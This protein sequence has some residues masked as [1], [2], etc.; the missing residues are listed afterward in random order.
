[1]EE[2]GRQSARKTEQPRRG[3]KHQMR[4]KGFFF[5]KEA[6]TMPSVA[7][8]R[9]VASPRFTCKGSDLLV[10]GGEVSLTTG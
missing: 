10:A 1:M 4:R 9:G 2:D 7:R 8:G 6:G 3:I 5:R